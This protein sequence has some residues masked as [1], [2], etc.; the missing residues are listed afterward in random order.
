MK[1]HDRMIRELASRTHQITC[2]LDVDCSCPPPAEPMIAALFVDHV[3]H[4][5]NDPWFDAWPES[6]DARTYAGSLP[7]IAHPPCQLWVNLAAVNWKR[8]RRER[9][10]WYPGGTDGGMFASALANVRRVGGVLEHPGS[11]FAWA[12]HGLARPDALGW[13]RVNDHE[14]TCEV[15]QNAYG[16]PARKRT[17]LWYCSPAGYA[18]PELNWTRQPAMC[19][20]GFQFGT[21]ARRP[22]VSKRAASRTP[23]AFRDE[24]ARLALH[25]AHGPA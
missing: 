3:G 9:P 18:P 21:D 14:W 10:A 24:L 19:Q 7:V 11:S 23:L 25:A 5:V 1:E 2:D 8:Y 12:A 6:R 22:V 13:T 16:F 4:Y 20:I 15:W 17:W